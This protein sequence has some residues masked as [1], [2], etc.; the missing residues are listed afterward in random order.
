MERHGKSLEVS[1]AGRAECVQNCRIVLVG[2][3]ILAAEGAKQSEENGQTVLR[4]EGIT[5]EG[6]IGT[7]IQVTLG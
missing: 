6:E 4:P 1:V 5:E 3:T 2:E 7:T